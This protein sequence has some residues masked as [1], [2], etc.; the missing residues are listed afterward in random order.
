MK[1]KA[2]AIPTL[3]LILTILS[4]VAYSRWRD[5]VSIVGKVSTGKWKAAVRIWEELDGAYTDPETGEPT[6]EPAVTYIAIDAGFP[7][8]FKLTIWVANRGSTKLTPVIVT[9]RIGTDFE[10]VN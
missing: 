1:G 7:T 8:L 2:L 9:D 6:S 5:Q 3:I 10:Q 4:G